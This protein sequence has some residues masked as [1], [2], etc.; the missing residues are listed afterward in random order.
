MILGHLIP[1]GTGFRTFQESNVNYNLQEMGETQMQPAV[2]L[3]QSFPLLESEPASPIENGVNEPELQEP[4]STPM[5]FDEFLG[6]GLAGNEPTDPGTG[7][8]FAGG[9]F[10]GDFGGD[11][12]PE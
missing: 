2:T 8:D 9:D 5:S 1:A 3:E 12:T 11:Y 4:T 6:S 7:G 10:G